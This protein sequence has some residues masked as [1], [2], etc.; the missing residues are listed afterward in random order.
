M[1]GSSNQTALSKCLMMISMRVEFHCKSDMIC[2]NDKEKD[3]TWKIR[4]WLVLTCGIGDMIVTHEFLG[5]EQFH[6]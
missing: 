6:S 2:R 5:N 3:R 4:L 1:D